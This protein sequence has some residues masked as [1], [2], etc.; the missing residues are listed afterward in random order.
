M[1]SGY[2][3]RR[4]FIENGIKYGI[5]LGILGWSACSK[6]S[7]KRPVSLGSKKSEPW[8]KISLA[9]WSLHRMLQSGK[10]DNLGF[11]KFTKEEFGLDAI[12]YVN[13][14]FT[15]G[16][17]KDYLKS[18]NQQANDHGVKQ[19]LIMVD[20]EGNLGDT[21]NKARTEA[22]QNHYKWVETAKSLGCHS[23]R[24]NVFGDGTAKDIQSAAITSLGTLAQF[25]ATYEINILVENH[26]GYSSDAKWL[27]KLIRQVNLE[28]CGTLPDFG[29]FCIERINGAQ[30]E[31]LCV[32]EYNK[33]LGVAE[34]MPYAKGVSAKSRNF[35]LSGNE[36]NT[37]YQKMLQ[38]V[39]GANYR[40]YI[41]IEYEGTDLSEIEGIRKTK[42][43][44]NL[45]NE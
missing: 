13:T 16:T 29:N 17:N 32:K 20:G 39:K 42:N 12:E 44:L 14:F 11:A 10:L 25:A 9:Q 40:G 31:G 5:G 8:F 34:L 3:S 35:E 27:G 41:G 7:S 33:Y 19:L 2:K 15:K 43:L 26:G 36:S 4:G 24:V 21:S 6:D 28:N 18:L 45:Y 30:W 38:I 23:I 1:K 22:V 37:D